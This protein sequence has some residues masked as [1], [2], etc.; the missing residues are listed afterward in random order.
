MSEPPEVDGTKY[1]Y[2]G[3][4]GEWPTVTVPFEWHFFDETGHHSGPIRRGE[5]IGGRYDGLQVPGYEPP[6]SL[7]FT[8]DPAQVT[9]TW[10]PDG[11]AGGSN[12]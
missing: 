1:S 7:P 6:P 11:I 10:N 4:G 12:P 9:I 5:I 2:T 3:D 8:I